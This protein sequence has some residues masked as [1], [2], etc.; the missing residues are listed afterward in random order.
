MST[1]SPP[2]SP[3]AE[4][5]VIG[6]MLATPRIVAEVA[7]TLLEPGHFYR[8]GMGVLY[9]EILERHY[10]DETIDALTIGT[11][12]AK[13]L[14]VSEKDA[15]GKLRALGGASA[16]QAV[17]H[18]RLI[19][20]AFDYRALLTLTYEIQADV[21][22]EESSPEELAGLLAQ[23]ATQIATSTLR[24]HELVDFEQLGRNYINHLRTLRAARAAGLE[25]GL[26]FGLKFM[27]D[28]TRGLRPGYVYFLAGEPGAGKSGVAWVLAVR[29]AER[30]LEKPE[31]KRIATLVLSLEMTEQISSTRVAQQL[32]GIDGGKLQDGDVD[33]AGLAAVIAAWKPR[34]KM[35]LYF[36]FSS[37]VRASQLRALVAEG[38]RRHGVG[39]VVIDHMRYFHMDDQRGF[40]SPAD[41]DEVK[42]EFLHEQIAK[43]LGV[44]VICLAHTTKGIEATDDRRPRLSHLRGG[45]MVAAH[46]DFVTFLYRPY[47][48]AS[49]QQI[50]DGKVKRTDAE[51]IYAKNR[52]QLEGTAY[53]HFDPSTMT[54]RDSWPT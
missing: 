49:Q 16:R 21:H 38:I 35:P 19:K 13:R 30:Q 36:N 24:A 27:D 37:A 25:V 32:S 31:D 7:G 34:R 45:G 28:W 39:L 10:A 18:A 47:M 6:A 12:C 48:H 22:V 23:R 15:I 33:D 44:A 50:D 1:S 14:G 51:L 17:T 11:L 54:V 42:A 4:A 29:S 3:E 46:A 26:K 9:A 52:H 41:E 20:R 43:E 53:L 2:A 5:S 40:R 8:E